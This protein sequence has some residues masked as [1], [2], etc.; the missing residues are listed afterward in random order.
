MERT[1]GEALSMALKGKYYDVV[2][3]SIAYCS[4]D[5]RG[6]F[7]AV[8]CKRYI[9]TLKASVYKEYI[10][11]MEEDFNPLTYPLKWYKRCDSTYEV[12]VSFLIY[13]A[14]SSCL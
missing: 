14:F 7:Y 8:S 5:V 13:S 9:M 3:D 6:I 2:C 1:D 12:I 10:N 4:N 11:T